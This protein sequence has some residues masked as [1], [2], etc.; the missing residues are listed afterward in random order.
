[1][2]QPGVPGGPDHRLDLPCGESVNV[3]ELD[4]GTR[5]FECD[6]GETHAVVMDTDSLERFV[7]SFLAE[8]LRETVETEDD[9]RE[10]STTHLMGLVSEV[11]SEAIVSADVS[12]DG[13]VGYALVWVSG[14]D[15]RDL[16]EVVV[17]HVLDLMEQAIE[18]ADDEAAVNEFEEY[19]GEFDV[20]TFVDEYRAERDFESEHDTAI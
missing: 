13:Q 19:V 6:C 1:M 2:A 9:Y 17:E 16:H 11:H 10:F 5:E 15:A 4:L 7:P 20:A 12:D 14:L 18:T 8:V 3:R